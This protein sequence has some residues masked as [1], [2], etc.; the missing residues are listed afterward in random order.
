[1]SAKESD[2]KEI[3]K[4][5]AQIAEKIFTQKATPKEAIG[6]QD[7]YLESIYAQGY[8]LYNTGKY[9][10]GVHL[11][12]ILVLLNPMESKYM[13]GLAACFH[14]LKDYDNAI[15][16]YTLCAALDPISPI[17]HYHTSDC[18]IQQKDEISAMISLEM[19]VDLAGNK[20]E[21]GKVKE[22]SLMTL[23]SIKKHLGVRQEEKSV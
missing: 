16:T 5:F 23:E 18:F 3:E 7:D 11:F 14:M 9:D 15:Q 6:V 17:P 12:R 19:A 13:L 8:R 22:R 4:E 20:P 10:E 1:M 2:K 21:F